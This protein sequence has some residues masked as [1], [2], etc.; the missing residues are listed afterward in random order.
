MARHYCTT[1]RCDWATT[2]LATAIRVAKELRSVLEYER[3]ASACYWRDTLN[4]HAAFP[5]ITVELR[6][7]ERNRERDVPCVGRCAVRHARDRHDRGGLRCSISTLR[8]VLRDH[9]RKKNERYAK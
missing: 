3:F 7:R 4:D 8:R 1:A 9:V 5:H 2:L 6:E